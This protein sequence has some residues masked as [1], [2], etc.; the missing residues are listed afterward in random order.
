MGEFRV[1]T[2]NDLIVNKN[3]KVFFIALRN[4]ASHISCYRVGVDEKNLCT[5]VNSAWIVCIEGSWNLFLL[6]HSNVLIL[7]R[8]AGLW[9]VEGKELFYN[10]LSH[11]TFMCPM[12]FNKF[13][14]DR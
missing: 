11:I 6:P 5:K 4:F 9:I 3:P 10:Q 1:D 14:L 7:Q 2:A 8:L 12:R 13:P